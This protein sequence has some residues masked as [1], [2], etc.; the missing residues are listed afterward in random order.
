M[1]ASLSCLLT[2]RHPCVGYDV[3][4]AAAHR[5]GGPSAGTHVKVGATATRL[6]TQAINENIDRRTYKTYVI[7]AQEDCS[8]DFST[9]ENERKV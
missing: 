8:S 9:A 1:A 3:L 4:A 2:C 5:V 7:V 6:G